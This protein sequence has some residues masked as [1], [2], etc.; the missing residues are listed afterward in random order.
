MKSDLWLLG[1]IAEVKLQCI[2]QSR[3]L[4]GVSDGVKMTLRAVGDRVYLM[5][6]R[7]TF[8]P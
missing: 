3:E 6:E 1:L 5:S 4:V 8:S 2:S 7:V